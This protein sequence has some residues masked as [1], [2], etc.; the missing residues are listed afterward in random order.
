VTAL[1]PDRLRT[2]PHVLDWRRMQQCLH[3]NAILFGFL[4][5]SCQLLLRCL[6]RVDIKIDAD[7][8]KADR[9]RF[10]HAECP[11]QIQVSLNCHL[12]IIRRYSHR[13]GDHLAGD[14]CASGHAPSSRSPEQ[15]PV[16]AP[17]T[18]LCA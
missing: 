2:Y 17:P 5:K 9:H 11:L 4:L 6:R 16:P 10:R 1:N 15:A 3:Y 7:A 18:P 8:F 14:L 13:G 12:D